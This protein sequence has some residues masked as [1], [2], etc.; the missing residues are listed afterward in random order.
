MISS[1]YYDGVMHNLAE[2]CTIF[3]SYAQARPSYAQSYAQNVFSV[4][5]VSQSWDNFWEKIVTIHIDFSHLAFTYQ[6]T[7]DY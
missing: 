1:E 2:L 6:S 7:Y 5:N 4:I 3:W